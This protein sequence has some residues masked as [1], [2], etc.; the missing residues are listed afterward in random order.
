MLCKFIFS[1]WYKVELLSKG[2]GRGEPGLV[3]LFFDSCALLRTSS[4]PTPHA[5][6]MSLKLRHVNRAEINQHSRRQICSKGR[7]C[8]GLGGWGRVT[9]KYHDQ[10]PTAGD[11]IVA[12]K[13]RVP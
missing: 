12:R 2:G 3:T 8:W 6:L 5:M 1:L 13:P 10:Q 11:N 4:E 7:G 9:Q